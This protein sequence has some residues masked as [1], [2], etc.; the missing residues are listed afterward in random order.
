MAPD[1]VNTR[2]GERQ[3]FRVGLHELDPDAVGLDTLPRLVQ[4]ALRQLQRRDARPAPCQHHRRH[5]VAAAEVENLTTRDVAQLVE[6]V[7][8]PGFVVEII[9]VREAEGF[10]RLGERHGPPTGLLVVE[11]AFAAEPV[12]DDPKKSG[13]RLRATPRLYGGTAEGTAGS[14][15]LRLRGPV[16]RRLVLAFGRN[17]VR[18][19]QPPAQ[20]D[21]PAAR[22]AEGELRPFLPACPFHQSIANRAAYPDHRQLTRTTW[23]F[24]LMT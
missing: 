9:G 12:H 22:A 18:A 19:A 7:A 24:S 5:A 16:F 4:I 8:Q 23:S 15:N 17:A 3:P 11:G 13:A 10:G 6:G 1:A 21:Q 20:V 14:G 2:V